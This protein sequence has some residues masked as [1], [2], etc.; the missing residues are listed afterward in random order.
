MS[1]ANYAGGVVGD[2]ETA[3]AAGLLDGTLGLA[4]FLGFTVD[5]V[6]VTGIDSGYTVTT[7]GNC[8]GGAFGIAVGGE[9]SNVQL[10]NLQSVTA[11]NVSG[12]FIGISGPGDLT[13]TG[14]LTVNLLGLDNVLNLQHLLIL[15]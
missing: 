5:G 12:G 2:I 3:N 8:A 10:K 1:A 4:S 11:Y 6:N 7:Q 15:K 14:G 9:I 13:G